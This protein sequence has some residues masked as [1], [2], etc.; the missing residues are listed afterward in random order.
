[1]LVSYSALLLLLLVLANTH[2]QLI[3]SSV[4][5]FNFYVTTSGA[6]GSLLS[7]NLNSQNTT[8]IYNIDSNIHTIFFQCS[9]APMAIAEQ[10][11]AHSS[12]QLTILLGSEQECLNTI[13][14]AASEAFAKPEIKEESGLVLGCSRHL[15]DWLN[16]PLTE[17][18]SRLQVRF[19]GCGITK[20]FGC[21]RGPPPPSSPPPARSIAM[22]AFLI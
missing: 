5:P 4:T 3:P 19:L 21:G 9:S 7:S 16:L 17:Y 20:Q 22:E 15:D 2:T 6:S 10:T 18:L 8:I 12:N 14:T 1:M 13:S 11:C